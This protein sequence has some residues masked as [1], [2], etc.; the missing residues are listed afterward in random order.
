[1]SSTRQ[2]SSWIPIH[3][4]CHSLSAAS[5]HGGH[6]IVSAIPRPSSLLPVCPVVSQYLLY[7]SLQASLAVLDFSPHSGDSIGSVCHLTSLQRLHRQFQLLHLNH[8]SRYEGRR[9]G[10]DGG[11]LKAGMTGCGAMEGDE[12]DKGGSLKAF[13]FRASRSEVRKSEKT[14][15]DE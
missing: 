9:D 3:R 5:I 1:M 12:R 7:P 13:T 6:E 15:P 14:V 11:L 8:G 2:A 4:H 10:G